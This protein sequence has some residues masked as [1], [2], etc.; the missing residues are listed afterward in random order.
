MPSVWEQRFSRFVRRFTAQRE[1]ASLELV[2]DLL[3]VLSVAQPDDLDVRTLRGERPCSGFFTQAAAPGFFNFQALVN[4]TD[5]VLLVVEDMDLW[6]GAGGI[7]A[8]ILGG[9]TALGAASGQLGPR[10]SRWIGTP[11]Q[12]VWRYG[13]TG[14]AAM[15]QSSLWSSMGT[16]ALASTVMNIRLPVVIAPGYSLII[17]SLAANE[18]LRVALRWRERVVDAAELSTP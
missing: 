8:G 16:M 10:D 2:P 15:G 6:G 3:P 18:A 9:A 17:V 12:A 7:Q 4:G 13:T 5:N 11:V 14:G 1:A